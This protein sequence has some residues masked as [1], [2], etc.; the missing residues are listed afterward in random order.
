M[1]VVFLQGRIWTSGI[2]RSKNSNHKDSTEE[3]LRKNENKQHGNLQ[4]T[5]ARKHLSVGKSQSP[6]WSIPV[7]C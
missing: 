3:F 4:M 6:L 2:H 5:I 7:N 1:N